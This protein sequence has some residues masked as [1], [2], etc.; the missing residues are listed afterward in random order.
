MRVLCYLPAETRPPSPTRSS[1]IPSEVSLQYSLERVKVQIRHPTFDSKGEGGGSCSV[2]SVL[3]G[4][5]SLS[6]SFGQRAGFSGGF[7]SEPLGVAMY[8]LL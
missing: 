6:W 4:G 5:L 2:L 8:W 3:S 1:L 7:L